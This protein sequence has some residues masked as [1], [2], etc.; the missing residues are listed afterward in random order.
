MFDTLIIDFIGAD[1][2]P[3]SEGGT[4][5]QTT[6]ARGALKRASNHATYAGSDPT[7]YSHYNV[8]QLST[9]GGSAEAWGCSSGG[10]L[11]AALETWRLGLWSTVGSGVQGY[12]LYFGG[13]LSKDFVLRRYDG[14][15]T[16]FTQIG[17]GQ[18][19][20][21]PVKMGLVVRDDGD[22]EAW[23]TFTATPTTWELQITTNDTTYPGPFYAGLGIEENDSLYWTCFGASIEVTWM[24]EFIRRP[25]NYQ[26]DEITMQ[27]APA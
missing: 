22:I 1:E 18:N 12:Q 15:I 27:V 8:E 20:D 19:S 2:N 17:P 26:G 4:W 6:P 14:G 25:W 5:S 3:L 21:Y 10:Q 23:A 7:S 24:P 11:G 16:N 9:A 13:A